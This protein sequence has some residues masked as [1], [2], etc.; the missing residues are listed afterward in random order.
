MDQVDQLIKKFMGKKGKKAAGETC[1]DHE[2]LGAFYEGRL[3]QESERRLREHIMYCDRCLELGSALAAQLEDNRY[4]EK[5]QVPLKALNRVVRLDPAR[6]H[7]SWTEGAREVV[8]DFARGMVNSVKSSGQAVAVEPVPAVAFR[9]GGQVISENLVAFKKEFLPFIAEVEVEKIQENRGEITVSVSEKETGRP[10]Q[11]MRV[12]L[13][14]PEKEL[15]S[16]I[17]EQ[18]QAVF[19]NVKFGK[20]LLRLSRQGKQIGRI[21]LNMKS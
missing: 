5:I 2:T 17:L 12:S 4:E 19:E 7:K 14:S 11:G 21:S 20:Y 8:V 16:Y 13:F 9:G 10:A 15:E 1:P 6:S 18:G 3:D